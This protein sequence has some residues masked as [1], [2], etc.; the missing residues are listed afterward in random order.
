MNPSY[1]VPALPSH[2]QGAAQ[3]LPYRQYLTDL[4]TSLFS[5]VLPLLPTAEELATKEEV[6]GLIERLIKTIEPSSRLASFG[7]SCNSFGLRNSDMDLVCLIDNK[8][9]ALHASDLVAMIGDLLER[10]TNFEVKPLPKARIPIIKLTLNPSPGLPYGI[11]CDIGFENRL[12]LENTRL[13]LTYATIDP[14][15]IRTLV[16][17]LKVWSKRRKINSPYRGTLSS[18][19]F[20]LMVIFFLVHVKNPPVLPNLQRIAPLRPMSKEE[21]TI[22]GRDVW[23]FDDTETLRKE[24]SSANFES[25]GELLIDFFRYY[26]HDFQYNNTVISIRAG[27][28]TKESKGWMNDI[29]VG[30][31]N[32]N[33]RDRNRL[34]IEDPFETPYNVARTVTKDG[35]YTIR[36]EFM[37]ATRILTQHRDQRDR[38][39]LALAELCM[40][41]E[42]ELAR[43]P[44]S[45]SPAPRSLAG[46]SRAPFGMTGWKTQMGASPYDRMPSS[47][48]SGMMSPNSAGPSETDDYTRR[49]FSQGATTK[50]GRQ[51]ES[52]DRQYSAQERWL[53][54]AGLGFDAPMAGVTGAFLG[55][56]A[57]SGTPDPSLRGRDAGSRQGMDPSMSYGMPSARRMSGMN[58]PSELPGAHGSA[59]API[60]PVKQGG[61]LPDHRQNGT[62]SA[63][64]SPR[65]ASQAR[66]PPVNDNRMPAVALPPRRASGN[67]GRGGPSGSSG[68]D[69]R[70]T[71]AG[72]ASNGYARFASPP[73]AAYISN[74]G[75]RRAY[76]VGPGHNAAFGAPGAGASADSGYAVYPQQ[77]SGTSPLPSFQPFG[78][79]HAPPQNGNLQAMS[80]PSFISPTS[81]LSPETRSTP[82]DNY[83]MYRM[84]GDTTGLSHVGAIGTR[85]VQ[86][87]DRGADDNEALDALASGLKEVALGL[88][89]GEEAQPSTSTEASFKL[90][91]GSA[92]VPPPRKSSA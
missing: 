17:F 23:F 3:S 35:L 71:H 56:R 38:A 40:E 84:K 53:A 15:R 54:Q 46:G 55:G 12:A 4:S 28:L 61:P 58:Y 32:E 29:D 11:A 82:L 72:P 20:T 36:G 74:A 16:L 47:A 57:S 43:A 86:D 79:A 67:A 26:S 45:A 33:A 80:P 24:W 92:N 64:V 34:C 68:F 39:V 6:R 14:A 49:S 51:P 22:D 73:S 88:D 59:S 48:S 44:R 52:S 70:T 91:S 66:L 78:G 10:E 75:A 9:A 8:E 89:A 65:Q 41:R 2:P 21:T 30:G 76:S 31:L 85:Q 5:F 13:L 90:P 25:V 81:L 27:H 1:T 77:H 19:G 60:S 87:S 50:R 18:Y 37:R 69:A 63:Q 83:P 42:D 62:W 7:S